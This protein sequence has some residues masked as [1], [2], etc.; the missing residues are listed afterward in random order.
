VQSYNEGGLV[1]GKLVSTL[2]A[3]HY[4]WY[5][6]FFREFCDEY[7]KQSATQVPPNQIK[8]SWLKSLPQLEALFQK[9]T[10]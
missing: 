1:D 5:R 3:P 8:P 9:S 6:Q 2:L 10:G 4:E 7:R